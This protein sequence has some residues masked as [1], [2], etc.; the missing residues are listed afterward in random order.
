M[1]R[2][3][4]ATPLTSIR[5]GMEIFLAETKSLALI[6]DDT[7]APMVTWVHWVVYNIPC[8]S[9]INEDSIP[10]QQGINDFGKKAEYVGFFHIGKK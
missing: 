9:R 5:A 1:E 3:G 10:G 2:T 6:V 7:D 4:K 8:V